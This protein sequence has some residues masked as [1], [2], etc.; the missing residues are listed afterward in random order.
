MITTD[1]TTANVSNLV[2][3]HEYT[4]S[5]I[6]IAGSCTSDPATN[7]FTALASHGGIIS[8]ISKYN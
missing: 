3:D 6:A 7:N 1:A 8:T 4:V 5:V 2:P